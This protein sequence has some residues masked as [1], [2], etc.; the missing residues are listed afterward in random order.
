MS[1]TLTAAAPSRAVNLLEAVYT[2]SIDNYKVLKAVMRQN[3]D[4]W[5]ESG[6][7]T[8]DIIIELDND[9]K[10]ATEELFFRSKKEQRSI[11]IRAY[12]EAFQSYLEC[13][14]EDAEECRVS[15]FW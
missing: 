15:D 8:A 2:G 1:D 12:R 6:H 11:K 3:F 9:Y 7:M 13:F 14:E 4:A 5:S 10:A